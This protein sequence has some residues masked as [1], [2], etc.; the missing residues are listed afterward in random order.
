VQR[1]GRRVD[2]D[3]VG[4]QRRRGDHGKARRQVF[5][6]LHLFTRTAPQVAGGH[7]ASLAIAVV[8]PGHDSVV[9]LNLNDG[10]Q[11]GRRAD[12]RRAE[13][14]FCRQPGR[15]LAGRPADTPPLQARQIVGVGCISG[16]FGRYEHFY[17]K[18]GAVAAHYL[19]RRIGAAGRLSRHEGKAVQPAYSR[20]RAA[21]R[22]Q[23]LP[24][25]IHK[26]DL[27]LE[28]G[29][30]GDQRLQIARRRNRRTAR[31]LGHHQHGERPLL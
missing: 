30:V 20:R 2:Q 31:F 1:D 23:D 10:F 3:V 13:H 29:Q 15:V 19:Q 24:V 18:A 22:S 7:G 6:R 12:A 26:L 21:Q 14:Q 28:A 17:L 25:T 8:D 5:Q 16:E 11:I 27:D 9:A 4:N